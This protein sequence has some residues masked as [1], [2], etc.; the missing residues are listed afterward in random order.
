MEDIC[1]YV[2]VPV[3]I[4]VDT[5]PNCDLQMVKGDVP[6]LAIEVKFNLA[7]DQDLRKQEAQ[8]YK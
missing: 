6:I 1:R 7:K 2:H 5:K 8:L 4:Q 3:G